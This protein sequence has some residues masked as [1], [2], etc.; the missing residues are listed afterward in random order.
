MSYR[1][2]LI[3]LLG[4][5]TSACAPY[6]ESG[7]YYRSDYYTSDRY[8]AP[9]YY[10]YDRYYVAP[11]PRPPVTQWHGNPRHDYGNR[12]RDDYRG[13]RDRHDYRDGSQRYPR[14]GWQ[15]N[16]PGNGGGPGDGPRGQGQWQR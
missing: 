16:G 6:Y 14:G 12:Q 9:G 8:A 4:S 3:A 1:I 15:S 7:S 13:D 2:L 5:M 11:Q 10:R